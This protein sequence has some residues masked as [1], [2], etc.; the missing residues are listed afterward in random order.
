MWVYDT[1]NLWTF[2]CLYYFK[3]IKLNSPIRM[4]EICTHWKRICFDDYE[5]AKEGSSNITITTELEIIVDRFSKADDATKLHIKEQLRKVVFLKTIDL[6]PLTQ[7]VKTNGAIEKMKTS[8][9]DSTTKH[10]PF[11]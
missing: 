2:M 5:S 11:H 9:A 1:G 6:K 4:D 7:P 3:K 8:Q 10:T